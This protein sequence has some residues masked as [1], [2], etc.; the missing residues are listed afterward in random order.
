MHM[1]KAAHERTGGTFQLPAM[2]GDL[3]RERRTGLRLRLYL[4]RGEALR[5][6]GEMLLL[7]LQAPLRVDCQHI[8]WFYGRH[9]VDV[10]SIVVNAMMHLSLVPH[11]SR[12]NQGQLQHCKVQRCCTRRHICRRPDF[13][14]PGARL[15]A[16]SEAAGCY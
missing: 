12:L 7:L 3:V 10:I 9:H 13:P 11:L 2:A 8:Q 6:L 1:P 14:E 15:G 4:L 16:F 5:R